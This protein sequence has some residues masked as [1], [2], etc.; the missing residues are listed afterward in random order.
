MA[1]WKKPIDPYKRKNKL[2]YLDDDFLPIVMDILGIIKY[3]KLPLKVFETLRTIER[4]EMLLKDG[5]S[6]TINS[7]HL[8]NYRGKS[9]AVD[10]VVW[11][12]GRF[13][14]DNHYKYWYEVLGA[15]IIARYP[16]SIRWGG[17]FKNFFDGAHFELIRHN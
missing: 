12:R 15:I 14:W 6:K 4:Q 11:T 17:T 2:I 5:Y 8:P 7:K 3:H 13:A 9:E 16:V 1:F 10:I